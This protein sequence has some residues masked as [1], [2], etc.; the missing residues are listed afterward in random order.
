MDRV[1][2]RAVVAEYALALEQLIGAGWMQLVSNLFDS[3]Q[4]TEE[5]GWLGMP[6]AMREWLGQRKAKQLRDDGIEIRNLEFESTIEILVK[7][8]RRDNHGVIRTRIAEHVERA[9][10]HWASLL[11]TLILNGATGTC[12]DGQYFFD[13]DHST[14]DSGSQSNKIDVDISALPATNHG[15]VTAPSSEE[16]A[17]AALKAIDQICSFV[18]DQ[19]EP[20]NE[21]A[22]QFL[23]MTP[24]SLYTPFRS[25]LTL[26]RGTD[27]AEMM[28]EKQISVVSN[29]RF[30]SWTD[31]F[32]VFRTDAPVKALIRQEEVGVMVS[33]LAEGSDFEHHNNAHQYGLNA[34]RNV[35]YGRWE[36]ACQATLT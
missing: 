20:M 1:T 8:L 9:N 28:S 13:T 33:A 7:H 15:V 34:S 22:T 10:S 36:Y 32:A 11:S 5:Y 2:S 3:N 26:P 25:G 30:G 35:G 4:G 18:D 21:T 27:V 12:Y 23:I 29:A 19:G 31:K 14:G 17:Q 6:P 16:A 24:I